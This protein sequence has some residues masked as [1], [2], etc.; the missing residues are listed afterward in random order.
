MNPVNY[1]FHGKASRSEYMLTLFVGAIIAFIISTLSAVVWISIGLTEAEALDAVYIT[2]FIAFHIPLLSAGARRFRDMGAH[3][4][5]TLL[6]LIPYV[7]WG[8]FGACCI[9]DSKK[10]EAAQ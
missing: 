8:V 1:S 4:G 10:E 9:V 7:G 6:H 3:P 2:L 5:L